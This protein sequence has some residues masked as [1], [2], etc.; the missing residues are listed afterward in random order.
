MSVY[1]EFTKDEVLARRNDAEIQAKKREEEIQRGARILLSKSRKACEKGED[2]FYL[3]KGRKEELPHI[4]KSFYPTES[5][6]ICMA[7]L[8]NRGFEP[9]LE[10]DREDSLSRVYLRIL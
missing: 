3:G 8:K 1:P 2:R 9:T 5:L 7:D 10:I 6:E 4:S